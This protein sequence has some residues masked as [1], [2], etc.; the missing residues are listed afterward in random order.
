MNIDYEMVQEK[1]P[2]VYAVTG[3]DQCCTNHFHKKIE[4]IYNLSGTK[5][6]TIGSEDY[7]LQPQTLAIADSYTPHRYCHA[8]GEQTVLV[9]PVK[10]C[11][12]YFAYRKSRVLSECTV[13]DSD[14]CKNRLEPFINR[15]LDHKSLNAYSLQANIDMLL[16]GICDKV[17]L[18]E[19]KSTPMVEN[20]DEI[21]QFIE[22]NY[23]QDITLDTLAAHFGYSKY[24]FSRTFNSQFHTNL[25]DYL[26][27]IR[28]QKTLEYL[29]KNKCSAT[30]AALN[31]GF[32][33][34]PTFYRVYKRAYP[35]VPLKKF[36]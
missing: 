1:F 15:I 10:F 29:A 27:F 24:Y 8:D 35:D 33:S 17:G 3:R 13:F 6:V 14:Y 34:M 5:T 31:N 26:A 12:N 21:L 25:N 32:N 23:A 18:K 22:D 19:Q 7:L 16:S 20:I 9:F 2:Q 30:T 36:L 4:L 28:L 11:G